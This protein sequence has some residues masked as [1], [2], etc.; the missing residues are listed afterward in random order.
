MVVESS[1][2]GLSSE[3][4]ALVGAA[5][6]GSE[7]VAVLGVAVSSSTA[8][9]GKNEVR[10]SLSDLRRRASFDVAMPGRRSVNGE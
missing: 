10:D 7:K 9:R 8:G 2:S 5:V 6:N 1:V 3:L 4:V